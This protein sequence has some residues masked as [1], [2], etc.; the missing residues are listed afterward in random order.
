M[1]DQSMLLSAIQHFTT[2]RARCKAVG[3][4]YFQTCT[5]RQANA[6]AGRWLLNH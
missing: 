2:L 1:A 5:F 3:S 4:M 6:Q